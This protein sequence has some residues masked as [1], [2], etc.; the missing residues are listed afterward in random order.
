MAAHPSV[1]DLV[2]PSQPS[3]NTLLKTLKKQGLSPHNRFRSILRDADFVASAVASLGR[4]PLV[5]NER[6]GSWYVEPARK[7]GSAYFKSTDGH[8]GQWGFSC[9]RLNL[10]L[11]DLIEE[12]DGCIIVD[13]TRRG[14]RMPDALSKTIPI[15]C[16]VI[17]MALFPDL[18]ASHT[19]HTPPNVVPSTEHAQISALLPTFLSSLQALNLDLPS[20]R[21]KLSKPLRPYWVTP[22]TRLQEQQEG[23]GPREAVFEDF[24][25]VVCCTASSRSS[26]ELSTFEGYV[27]GAADDTEHWAMGLTAPIF[28]QHAD[29]LLSTD[30]A[31]LPGVIAR[32]L[33]EEKREREADGD[34]E[35]GVKVSAC[36]YVC[37][38]PLSEPAAG[39]DNE[40]QIVFLDD[41]VTPRDGWVKGPRRMELGLGNARNASKNLRSALPAVS[42]FVERFLG[43]PSSEEV[44]RPGVQG[45]RDPPEEGNQELHKEES[46]VLQEDTKGAEA[47]VAGKS[48]GNVR[49]VIACPTGKDLSLATALAL[50]CRLFTPDDKPLQ[51]PL[52]DAS[53]NKAAIRQR[54]GRMMIAFPGANPQRAT[55]QSVNRRE[56]GQGVAQ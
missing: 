53:M 23:A 48:R 17:N 34:A 31:D 55:L 2:L 22:E 35:R 47:E 52:E 10:H 56:M 28:W 8:T 49:I 30:D 44:L 26:S 18:P 4:R 27:Q 5:A 25:P 46:R 40:C 15:W 29:L 19:L 51:K 21:S 33:E 43:F 13:S 42:A 14:K 11:L 3:L 38:L 36:M 9:R 37:Q 16:A 32:L 6:C 20:L 50:H 7:A 1:S 24:R 45:R 39:S 41:A 54:L 12:N